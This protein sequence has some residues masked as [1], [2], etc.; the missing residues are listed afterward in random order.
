MTSE[1]A[2]TIVADGKVTP[3]RR[4]EEE[5]LQH[6]EAIE[7]CSGCKAYHMSPDHSIN[8]IAAIL[9]KAQHDPRWAEAMR[10]TPHP[11]N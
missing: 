10:A 4:V 5:I 6:E 11:E 1:V 3:L 8:D 2:P 9:A 7:W